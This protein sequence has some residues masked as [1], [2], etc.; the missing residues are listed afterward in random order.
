MQKSNKRYQIDRQQGSP[1]VFNVDFLKQ[2]TIIHMG[3][4]GY[5]SAVNRCSIQLEEKELI[6]RL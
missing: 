6:G 4:H 1:N 2:Y 3:C 5:N